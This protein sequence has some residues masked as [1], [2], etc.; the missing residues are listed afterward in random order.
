MQTSDQLLEKCNTA[1][2][3][4]NP[5]MMQEILA[6]VKEAIKEGKFSPEDEAVWLRAELRMLAISAQSDNQKEQISACLEQLQT[7]NALEAADFHLLYANGLLEESMLTQGLALFPQDAMLICLL[8]EHRM[9]QENYREAIWYFTQALFFSTEPSYIEILLQKARIQRWMTLG[10][11]ETPEHLE[12]KIRLAIAIG[13]HEAAEQV[14][15]K[16]KAFAGLSQDLI[17]HLTALNFALRQKWKEARSIWDTMYQEGRLDP[18]GA[19]ISAGKYAEAGYPEHALKLLS[20]LLRMEDLEQSP[21]FE[22]FDSSATLPATYHIENQLNILVWMSDC[23]RRMRNLP[24]AMELVEKGLNIKPKHTILL[25]NKALIQAADNQT[26]EAFYTLLLSKKAGLDP[27]VWEESRAELYFQL[28]DWQK[29]R[30][31][32]ELLHRQYP[33]NARSCFLLGMAYFQL[34]MDIQAIVCLQESTQKFG[35]HPDRPQALYTLHLLYLNK[36]FI[37]DAAQMIKALREYYPKENPNYRQFSILL[38]TL[39]YDNKSFDEAAELFLELHKQ[40]PLERPYRSYL[41]VLVNFECVKIDG[42]DLS[43]STENTY[44]AAPENPRQII[45]MPMWGWY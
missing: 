6:E 14:L 41:E 2:Q 26:E 37:G 1:F 30:E 40:A 31:I 44:I 9:E 10:K 20:P 38:A 7:S 17:D 21:S 25:L 23:L 12:E 29:A 28:Q 8:G 42:T 3:E 5:A 22:S 16:A 34:K 27:K 39:W 32:L 43:F 13:Q 11:D 4:G 35:N 24:K 18:E 19:L 45:T 15:Q 36:H 33:K